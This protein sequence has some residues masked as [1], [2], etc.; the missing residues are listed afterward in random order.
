MLPSEIAERIRAYIE[1]YSFTSIVADTGGLGK[2]I[3][4]EF[5]QRWALPIRA[6]EKKNK[7]SYVEL[8]NSDLASGF[9]R[10]QADSQLLEEWR[11]LQLEEARKKEDGRFELHLSYDCL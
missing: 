7:A 9:V 3:V 4:E 8:M 2:S 5:K 1:Q 10:V 6:A 11:L